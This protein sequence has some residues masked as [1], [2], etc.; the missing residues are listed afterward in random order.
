M[1]F[2][3][4][5]CLHYLKEKS[6]KDLHVVSEYA[7]NIWHTSTSS[8]QQLSGVNAFSSAFWRHH[9]VTPVLWLVR[10]IATPRSTTNFSKEQRPLPVP[11]KHGTISMT[12]VTPQKTKWFPK[13]VNCLSNI[14]SNNFTTLAL[15]R[16]NMDVEFTDFKH[17]E[18]HL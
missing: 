1:S 14:K 8:V 7:P 11:G 9:Q 6:P 5:R 16:C 17:T 4:S 3:I 10:Y 18:H 13:P 2:N 15:L 12:L